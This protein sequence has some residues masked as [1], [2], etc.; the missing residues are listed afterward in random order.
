MEGQPSMNA[1][2][3]QI[4]DSTAFRAGQLAERERIIHLIDHIRE[5]LLADRGDITFFEM[6]AVRR[7]LKRLARAIAEAG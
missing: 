2:I 1:N 7:S 4:P 6:N 5:D 3:L